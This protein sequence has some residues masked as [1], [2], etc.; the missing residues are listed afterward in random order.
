MDTCLLDSLRAAINDAYLAEETQL[1]EKLAVNLHDYDAKAAAVVARQLV[2]AVRANSARQTLIN[3]LLHEYQ[4]NSQEGIVLMEIAEALLRIPDAATQDAFLQ[5]KL[6]SV[7]WNRHQPLHD[8][9]LVRLMTGALSITGKIE[10]WGLQPHESLGQYLSRLSTPLIRS[11]FKQGMQLLAGQFIFAETIEDAIKTMAEQRD[12]RYSF[13]MLGESALTAKDADRFFQAYSEAISQLK[14]VANADDTFANPGIS[15]KLSALCPRYEPLQKQ[16]AVSELSAKLLDLAKQAK[17][18]NINLTVD[19]EESERLEMSL[20]IFAAVFTDPALKNWPGLG[21]AVQAYQKRSLPVI[22][23]LAALA[24]TQHRLIPIRLVK[25]AYW[26]GEIKRAQESGLAGYPVFTRKSATDVAYLACAQAIFAEPKAF[27]PQFATHNAHTVAAVLTLANV[28]PNFEFQRLHGMGEALFDA[29]AES[30]AKALPCR[31]YAPVGNFHDLLPYLVR[32][33]LENGA[34]TSFLNRVENPSIDIDEIVADPLSTMQQP[35]A[36]LVPPRKL[37]GQERLNSFGYNF[38]DPEIAGK[39]QAALDQLAGRA[40]EAFPI[41]DGNPHGGPIQATYN[42]CNSKDKIGSVVYAEPDT[43]KHAAARALASFHDWRRQ[44]VEQRIT[45]LHKTAELFESHYLELVSLCIREGGRTIK[46]ALAEVREAVDYCRYY[47]AEAD[48]LFHKPVRLP[49][50]TGEE[51]YLSRSGHG[52]LVCISPWNFPIA[53]FSGQICAALAAGNTV[54]AKPAAQTSLTAMRCIQLMHQAGFPTNVLQFL[55]AEGMLIAEHLLRF[56]GLGG[57]IFTG[58]TTTARTINR[59]LAQH[60][61]AIVPLI[62][63]TGGQNVMIADSSAH[64]EQLVLD[65]AISAFNSAGQRCSALRVLFVQ[66]DIAETVIALLIGVMQELNIGNPDCFATDIGPVIND[67]AAQQL[68]EHVDRMRHEARILHQVDLDAKLESGN[69]FPPT[70]IEIESITQLKQEVFGPILHLIR[71]R[72]DSLAAV[73]DT[74]NETGYGLTLGIHSRIKS[75]IQ[76]IVERARVG[77]IYVNRNMIG[78]V[79]GVQPFG[80]MGLSGTGPKA[81]GPDY[82]RR[83]TCEQ[84][85]TINS[86]AVGGNAALLAESLF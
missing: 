79:V 61:P 25:G 62:A 16:R 15:V 41:I 86:A 13:D 76:L 42:P 63:E 67:Q 10:S 24:E 57:V 38:S 74:V 1:S 14:S 75:H 21:M 3:T 34:N 60:Q 9:L 51:N 56:P 45:Y 68:S 73:I 72:A 18:A 78:A 65:A 81:G 53:I 12:L 58:S 27:Y 36:Q 22:R 40:W 64:I 17:D 69:F 32:R 46:D 28:H 35:H 80:G 55:P 2:C 5:D 59:Q 71:F 44:P 66:E 49:G 77:N 26:D 8:R 85:V 48:R 33:L 29:L 6:S 23:W 31:V 82:L 4:L 50:P 83:L 43:I 47:A 7:A 30:D 54:I 39:L 37:Y 11:A 19:A 52:A 70:L 84:T 20:D